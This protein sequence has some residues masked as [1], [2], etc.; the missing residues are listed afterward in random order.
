MREVRG[1]GGIRQLP[2]RQPN[3]PYPPLEVLEAGQVEQ[4]HLASLSLLENT[5]MK[6]MHAGARDL[7]ARA[8][9]EVNHDTKMVRFD[10][11]LV[12]E[13]VALA[14]SE[15]TLHARNPA[16]NFKLGGNHLA[17]TSVGGPAYCQDLDRGRRRG[18]FEE[19]CDYI[20]RHFGDTD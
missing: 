18:T 20:K 17:F 2:W 1:G 11:G 19:A 5:G 12:M 7:L 9:A 14:P 10:R 16:K 4:I 15:I 3:N 8:G 13:K 6:V